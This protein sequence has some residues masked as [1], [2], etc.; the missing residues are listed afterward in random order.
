MGIVEATV[1]QFL[2][3][4]RGLPR[5]ASPPPYAGAPREVF[6]ETS[7]QH[8]CHGLYWPAPSGRPTVL[9]LHGNAQ[10]V[11]EWALVRDDLAPL[12][13]GLL[14]VDYPGYGKSSGRPS[15]PAL[16]ACG[17]A[18]L[19]LLCQQEGQE[20][21][22]IILF[23]KSLGG[24]VATCVAAEARV[25]GVVLEST[26]RSIPSVVNRLIPFLSPGALL[27]SE[28][29]DS[30]SRMTAIESPVLVVHGTGDGLIPADEG[31]ALYR[32]AN[33]P[34]SL[35]L[36]EGA[37]HNDVSMVAGRAYGQRLRAWLDEISG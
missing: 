16:Y 20:P 5:D 8:E 37:G 23:G 4:P 30:L 32:A 14:L 13:C 10:S 6:F 11:F 2:Y 27:K 25:L 24:G 9:Y 3:H 31:E 29:Y 35:Y 26:F 22:R 18:A 17:R 1:R 7:R 12:D 15:E 33:E 19:A 36:V 21:E 28:R 34:K